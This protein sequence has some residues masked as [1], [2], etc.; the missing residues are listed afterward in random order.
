MLKS[1]DFHKFKYGNELLIDLIRLES[2]WK[3]I[4]DKNPHKLSYYDITLVTEGC[5]FFLRDGRSLEITP[6]K[7]IFSSPGEVR[8]WKLDQVPKGMVL[9]FKEEFL[10]S[11]LNDEK[12]VQKLTFFQCPDV[13]EFIIEGKDQ[14]YLI[15]ILTEIENEIRGFKLNDLHILK[16][17][18]YQCLSWLNRKFKAHYPLQ[19]VKMDNRHI[20]TFVHLIDQNFLKQHQISFYASHINITAGHLNDLCK[21][22]LGVSAKKYIQIKLITEAKKL[23]TYT[24]LSIA[25]IADRLNFEDPSY[26]TR[27]F[28]A[29][30]GVTPLEYRRKNP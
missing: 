29:V 30:T 3:Y 18:I 27:A 23:I 12:F 5:G 15:S 2:L 22:C 11:F 7:I 26:F 9:I 10:K 24:D 19:G 8:Q 16:A 4:S 21:M 14:S 1:Y 25:Q 13:S 20:Q 17:L 28:K 6:G